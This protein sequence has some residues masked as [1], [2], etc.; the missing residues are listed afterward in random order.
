VICKAKIKR[1]Q[2]GFPGKYQK[3]FCQAIQPAQNGLSRKNQTKSMWMK[4]S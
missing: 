2:I 4:S 1:T 3:K